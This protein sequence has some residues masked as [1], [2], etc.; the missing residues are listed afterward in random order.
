MSARGDRAESDAG[1]SPGGKRLAFVDSLRGIAAVA[2]VIQRT[3]SYFWPG[4]E[5]SRG[6]IS[7]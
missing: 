1:R 3:A 5:T 6:T 7:G 2:V 4:F